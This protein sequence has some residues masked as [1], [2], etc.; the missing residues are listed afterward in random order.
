MLLSEEKK[1]FYCRYRL[2]WASMPLI[3]IVNADDWQGYYGLVALAF[4][5]SGN[6]IADKQ[7]YYEKGE[8]NS[9][10]VSIGLKT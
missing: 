7:V 9:C 6:M 10:I 2:F 8:N 1:Q 3:C 5:L 4:L